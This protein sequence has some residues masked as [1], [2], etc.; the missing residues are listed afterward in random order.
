MLF[1]ERNI[2]FNKAH[3]KEFEQLTSVMAIPV[4]VFGDRVV[5]GYNFAEFQAAADYIG[6]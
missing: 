1:E 3:R 6:Y 4:T 2:L 5:V